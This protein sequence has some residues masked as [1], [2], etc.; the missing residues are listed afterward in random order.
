MKRLIFLPFCKRRNLLV[1]P[2]KCVSAFHSIHRKAS[3]GSDFELS[4]DLFRGGPW[5]EEKFAAWSLKRM[6]SCV[7]AQKEC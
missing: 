6:K 7:E 3:G 2:Q 5:E 4:N 1:V